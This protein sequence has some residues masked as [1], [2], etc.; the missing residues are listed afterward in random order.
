M[1]K[2]THEGKGWNEDG[3]VDHPKFPAWAERGIQART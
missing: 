1:A 2:Q 3:K